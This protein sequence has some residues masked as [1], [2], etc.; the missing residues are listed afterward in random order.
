[1][2][3]LSSLYCL[4]LLQITAMTSAYHLGRQSLRVLKTESP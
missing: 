2:I 3:P 4:L 1:M